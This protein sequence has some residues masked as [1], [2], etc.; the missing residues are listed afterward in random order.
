MDYTE[1][2]H[3]FILDETFDVEEW[4]QKI[5]HLRP[6][7]RTKLQVE[8]RYYRL[9]A[10][11]NL[12]FRHRLDSEL[13]QLTI[14]AVGEDTEVRTEINLNLTSDCQ[15]DAVA[16]FVS[17]LGSPNM[18]RI[19]KDIEVYDFR[20]CEV[21][22]YVASASDASAAG[23]KASVACMEFEAK[24]YKDLA[25]AKACLSLYESLLGFSHH[26]RSHKSLL[27]ILSKSLESLKES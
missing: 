12:V 11:P 19:E 6:L 2:E 3:K 21:V 1:V 8:D 20:D 23:T 10:F 26:Q 15:T 17:Q 16:A 18:F 9:A 22:Y 27:E 25:E 24:A 7:R 4:R 13:Q 5:N 14:K